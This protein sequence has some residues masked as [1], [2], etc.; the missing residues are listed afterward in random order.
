[1]FATL[2]SVL[3]TALVYAVALFAT[4]AFGKEDIMML[5]KGKKIYEKLVKMKL[6]K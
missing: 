3:T 1:M 5:P 2:L 6:M 4:R